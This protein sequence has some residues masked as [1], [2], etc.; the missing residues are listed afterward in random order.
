MDFSSL[1]QAVN[2]PCSQRADC[3]REVWAQHQA[4]FW[5][6]RANRRRTIVAFSESQTTFSYRDD[7]NLR[8]LGYRGGSFFSEWAATHRDFGRLPL[9]VSRV[10]MRGELHATEFRSFARLKHLAASLTSLSTLVEKAADF[11]MFR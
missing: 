7:P 6:H 9:G 1:D 5:A 3:R 8:Q 10:I 2:S 11:M 4:L